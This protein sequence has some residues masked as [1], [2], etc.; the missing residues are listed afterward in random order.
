MKKLNKQS[1]YS[2][3]YNGDINKIDKNLSK[4]IRCKKIISKQDKSDPIE[5]E[6]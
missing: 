4:F 5:F 2:E 1:I 3:L 6:Y